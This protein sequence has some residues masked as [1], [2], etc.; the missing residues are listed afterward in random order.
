M[1]IDNKIQ[2][3]TKLKPATDETDKYGTLIVVYSQNYIKDS[4]GFII[5]FKI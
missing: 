2:R 5:R 3:V 1:N 4:K